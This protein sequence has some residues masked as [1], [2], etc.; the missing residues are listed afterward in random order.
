V[1]IDELERALA[2]RN[3]PVNSLPGKGPRRC[4]S[5]YGL[6]GRSH[7]VQTFLEFLPIQKSA[8]LNM[9]AVKQQI[10]AVQKDSK[11]NNGVTL[12][13]VILAQHNLAALH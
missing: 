1:R 5:Y 13:Q 3:C 12:G 6:H 2:Q 11:A 7:V 10:E 4:P 9:A 8:S